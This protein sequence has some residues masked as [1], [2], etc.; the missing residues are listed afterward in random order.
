ME[1]FESAVVLLWIRRRKI[2]G[3]G[4]SGGKIYLRFVWNE[5]HL[6]GIIMLFESVILMKEQYKGLLQNRFLK[7]FTKKVMEECRKR[8]SS[9]TFFVGWFWDSDLKPRFAAGPCASSK[10][11]FF[12]I[13]R[14]PSIWRV[15]AKYGV[16]QRMSKAES[17]IQSK[18]YPSAGPPAVFQNI[19]ELCRIMGKEML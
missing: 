10:D 9:I 2:F 13:F 12:F 15:R 5:I 16:D 4:W 19:V 17:R 8:Y 7:Y 3:T 18:D 6:N 1:S 14:R 11:R